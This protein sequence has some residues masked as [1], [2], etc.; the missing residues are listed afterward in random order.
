MTNTRNNIVRILALAGVAAA[1]LALLASAPVDAS[2]SS[3][4]DEFLSTAEAAPPN[5]VFLLDLSDE[6]EEDCHEAADTGAGESP[7]LTGS[8]CLEDTLD[9]IDQLTQHYDWAYFGIV[10]TED[11]ASDNYPVAIAPLGSSHAEISTALGSVTG[12]GTDTRNLSEAL[13]DIGNDYL[14]RSS[15]GDT[16]T[17]WVSSSLSGDDFCNVPIQWACQETHVITIT[18][19]RPKD[20][21]NAGLG[22][23]SISPDTKCTWSGG[24]TTG[25]DTDCGYD[26]VVYNVYNDDFRSDLTGDQNIITHTVAIKVS[27]TSIAEELYGNS[28][29]QIGNEGVYTVANSGD[30]ILGSIM[31][32]MSYIRSGT[33]S[34]STPVLSV[35]GERIIYSFYEVSGDN[36][37]AEGHVR[38]YKIDTDPTSL[39]YG[40]VVYD[41][42]E[43]FG[44]AQWDAGDLLVSR[45]VATS[46]NN[47]DDMDGFGKRDIF[48]F[49]PEIYDYGESTAM[50]LAGDDYHRMGFDA[51]LTQAVVDHDA[52]GHDLLGDVFFDNTDA[53]SDGCAD[54]LAYDFTKDGCLVDEDDMQEMIDFVRGLSSAE[55]RY[56]TK[57][58]G[59]WKLGDS[60]HSIPVVAGNRDGTFTADTSYQEFLKDREDD[61][62]VVFIAANDGMLHAFRL[63]D[64]PLT[65]TN[66]DPL[67][68]EDADEAGEELW[69]WIPAY[70]TYKD[71]DAEWSGGLTDMLWYGRTFLFDGSP[72]VEDVW[73]D[74][75][76]DGIKASD[77]SE[78]R[79]IIVVQQGKGG[80]VTLAL[81][82]TDP[83]A[84]EFLWEQTNE[85]D[86]SAMGYTVS[87]PVVANLY[88]QE[89]PTDPKDAWTV[90]WGGGRAV[91]YT[92]DSSYYASSEANLYF[93]HVADDY[94][95]QDAGSLHGDFDEEGSNG[96][97]D[98]SASGLDSDSDSRYEYAYISGALAAVDT[99]SD[100]DVDVMYFAVTTSYEPTDMGGG[101]PTDTADP[102][103]TWM[104][105]AIIDVSDVD[106]P[107]WCEFY[108]PY[109][110]IG[111]RPEV[112]YAATTAWHSD[113]GL[114]VYWGTGSPYD[115]ESS[116]NGYF[117]AMKDAAP[118]SCASGATALT[119]AGN[120]GY[121]ELNSGEG[122]TG[123]PVVYAGTV[124][125][126][127]YEPASDR[128]DG[129]TGRI[130]ALDFQDCSATTDLDGDGSIDD[131]TDSFVS[132]DSYN[133][134]VTVSENGDV[135]YGTGDEIGELTGASD[136]FAQVITLGMRDVF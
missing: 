23:S 51:T 30:E 2:S 39:T 125:F 43:Q 123:D 89:T 112:Y 9:A 44:G 3:A 69:A 135:Y 46:E 8:S 115:R 116:D 93:W 74:E 32:V 50:S 62:Q 63:Y 111:E 56:I 118:L 133:S 84:P 106:D 17:G 121:Y 10:G 22:H 77:G 96:H 76:L 12:S 61:P 87:R 27:G 37:L 70:V 16:C 48:T 120:D 99:N 54:D 64:D 108:D 104:Y 20:D 49:I 107:E 71:R 94:W 113:G 97:P 67:S 73:Y 110:D 7:T 85:A 31:T 109:A 114:G 100:G 11:G 55:F 78:W 14:D 88:N 136:P 57:E 68:T 86:P 98:S 18:V 75:N 79:R 122:L 40:D 124:Y 24:I 38:G 53:D 13:Y 41:G 6:M 128:C 126:S 103:K 45:P 36:P 28:V 47:P 102:G 80:P 29:D 52:A 92:T 82:I 127:T 90:I 83:T 59:T 58:R 101:G 60:P 130:Y 26:N 15:E 134:G 4:G 19:D 129:G 132:N 5:V 95:N 81:D 1:P 21:Y 34:R 65:T 66:P 25:T 35:D 72:V 42:D 131:A 119:C 117:F 105:K 91:P 33:Y